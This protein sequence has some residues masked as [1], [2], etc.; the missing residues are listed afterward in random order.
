VADD[1]GRSTEIAAVPR[2]PHR[3]G[4]RQVGCRGL[5]E[6]S[7]ELS[8]AGG[9]VE[10]PRPWLF[11][12]A[13]DVGQTF[14]DHLDLGRSRPAAALRRTRRA[15]PGCGRRPA[16]FR[17]TSA[18]RAADHLSPTGDAYLPLVHL[19]YGVDRDVAAPHP[20]GRVV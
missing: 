19:Y 3:S 16:E 5:V 9:A 15:R 11:E 10:A 13:V 18:C 20:G 1:A 6:V 17:H 14:R 2:E 12:F 7:K 4:W 8:D